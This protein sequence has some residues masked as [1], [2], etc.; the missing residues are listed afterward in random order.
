[1]IEI[2]FLIVFLI[3]MIYFCLIIAEYIGKGILDE[4]NNEENN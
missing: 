4:K 3:A 2:I 1:M